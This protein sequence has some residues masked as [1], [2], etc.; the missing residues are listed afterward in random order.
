MSSG[1][2]LARFQNGRMECVLC[3]F[4]DSFWGLAEVVEE[5]Y[6]GWTTIMTIEHLQNG[7]NRPIAFEVKDAVVRPRLS[8]SMGTVKQTAR[9]LSLTRADSNGEIFVLNE[10]REIL[11]FLSWLDFFDAEN[12]GLAIR[13]WKFEESFFS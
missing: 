12:D 11:K 8:G 13:H 1:G 5:D 6:Y 10:N 4:A 2:D 9:Y 7:G 3:N